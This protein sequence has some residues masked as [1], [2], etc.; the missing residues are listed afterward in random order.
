MRPLYRGLADDAELVADSAIIAVDP[1][2]DFLT[3][4]VGVSLMQMRDTE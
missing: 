4:G 2:G 1:V 3:C